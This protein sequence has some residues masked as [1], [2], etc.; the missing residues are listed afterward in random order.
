MA[1]YLDFV[2]ADVVRLSISP[3]N[4]TATFLFLETNHNGHSVTIPLRKL[5]SLHQDIVGLLEKG[6][7]LFASQLK[8]NK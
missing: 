4:R 1:R 5:E 7:S 8:M 3:E 6:P 2:Q